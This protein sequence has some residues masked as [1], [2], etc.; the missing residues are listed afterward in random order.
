[1]NWHTI[2]EDRDIR[3][4]LFELHAKTGKLP[5]ECT[6]KVG[7]RKFMKLQFDEE[8]WTEYLKEKGYKEI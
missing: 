4:I 7:K 6:V 1:M 2:T 8:M 3:D 5:L